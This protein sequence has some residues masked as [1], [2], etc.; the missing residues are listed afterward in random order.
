MNA[1]PTLTLLAELRSLPRAYWVLVAGWFVNRFGTFVYPFLTL[2]LTERGHPPAAVAWVLAASGLGQFMSSLLGGYYSDRFGRRSTLVLG[3]FGHAAAI[4]SLYFATALP[5]MVAL[6]WAAGFASGFYM[7]ASSALLADVVPEPMRL[8]AYS[9]Q[10]LAINAGFA[11]GS[12]AA[13]FI[14]MISVFWLFAGDA[15]TTATFGLIAWFML[16]R[17]V[18]ASAEEA[19][20]TEAWRVLR[21]DHAFW[22]LFAATVLSS[23]IFI[24]F[25]STFALE[26]KERGLVMSVFGRR[27][28]PEQVFGC[29]LGWNGLMVALFELPMTRWTQRFTARHVIMAGYLMMGAG[30]AMNAWHGGVAMLFVAMT[31]FTIGEMLSQPMRSAYVAQLAPKHMRG[32]YMGALAMGGTLASVVGPFISLPLHDRWPS[33][34]W[35]GCGA[36]GVLAAF[37]LRGSK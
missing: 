14:M 6:M 24:Q 31:I 2:F 5:A 29:V 20:W 33:A 3:C 34:L 9:M 12:S 16:P 10:R 8:R 4:F 37:V 25:S 35:L 26:V 28:T 19:T 15:L 30:F 22:A 13:G 11:C 7:P 18:K 27:L 23:F 17:G 36:L 1:R 32:R 21:K